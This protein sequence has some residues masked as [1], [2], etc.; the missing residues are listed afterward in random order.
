[1]ERRSVFA[2]AGAA[3]LAGCASSKLSSMTTASGPL[4][5][6]HVIAFAPGGGVLSDAVGVELTNRGFTVL[7]SGSTI[8]M[9]ARLNLNEVEIS[10]PEGVSKLKD[11]GVDAL[12]TVRAVGAV[13]SQPQS[14]SVRLNSTDGGKVLA[15]V[16]WQNGW[17]GIQGSIADRV[18]RS[19]LTEAASQIADA[20]VARVAR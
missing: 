12:L 20:L 3:L 18:M 5:R 8:T 11:Q 13:D 10:K 4:P 9:M 15:G 14:A 2:L 7:D 19:G 6:V 1:M 17:G 16:T